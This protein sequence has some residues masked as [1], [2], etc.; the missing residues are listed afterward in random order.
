MT[1][2]FIVVQ[3]MSITSD[4][5]T[6]AHVHGLILPSHRAAAEK[7]NP[8]QLHLRLGEEVQRLRILL[9]PLVELEKKGRSMSLTMD[10][11]HTLRDKPDIEEDIEKLEAASR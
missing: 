10:D 7:L 4:S 5:I 3:K 6:N 1:P 8:T 9:L 2:P 11:L